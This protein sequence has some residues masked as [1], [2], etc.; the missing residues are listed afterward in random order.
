VVDMRDDREIPDQFLIPAAH[1][2]SP[3]TLVLTSE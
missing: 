1:K 3:A 2:C